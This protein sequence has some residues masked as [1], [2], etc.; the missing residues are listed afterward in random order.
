MS[1]ID[2]LQTGRRPGRDNGVVLSVALYRGY[3]SL[4]I[5]HLQKQQKKPIV[6]AC[7]NRHTRSVGQQSGVLQTWPD[8]KTM[9]C[10]NCQY[11]VVV[12]FLTLRIDTFKTQSRQDERQSRLS[13]VRCQSPG[14][15]VSHGGLQ[16]ASHR[17]GVPKNYK[18]FYRCWDRVKGGG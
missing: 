12:A 11:T 18:L 3:F 15:E 5:L 4:T 17:S 13:E 14:T 7:P 8:V 10:F 16:D 1:V 2:K 6:H 9:R